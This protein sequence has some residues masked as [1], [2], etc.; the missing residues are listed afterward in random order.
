ML[1]IPSATYR[2]QFNQYFT[3]KQALELIPYFKE[4]G[5]SDYYSSPIMKAEPGSL[6][7]YDVLD[8][9]QVNPEIGT[10]E[11]FGHLA[12]ALQEQEMGFVLDIVPNH[13]C[14]SQP[15][16]RW[17]TD[18]LENGPSSLYARYFNIVWKPP[19]AELRNKILLAV[20][21]QQYGKVI[22]NQE[23][24]LAYEGG[25]FFV[26]YGGSHF[27]INPRTWNVILKPVVQLAE[28][29]LGENHPDILEIQSIL[30]AIDHLPSLS[31][32]DPEK[33]KERNREKEIVKKRLSS[34]LDN[35]PAILKAVQDS[36]R[37]LNGV[38]GDPHSF[39]RLEE[40]L[41]SQAYRLSYWRVT[42]DE[43]NYRR[44]F[45]VSK[46]A[47]IRVE[48]EEVFSA[49]HELVFKWIKQKWVTGL[50]V[51][52]VDGLF[53]PEYYLQRLQQGCWEAS[54]GEKIA[55]ANRCFYVLVEKILVGKEQ[56]RSQWPVYGTTGYDF[57]NLVNGLFIVQDHG[58]SIQLIYDH[59][60]G[61]H[62]DLMEI[63]YICKKLILIA[64]MSSELHILA[65][66]LE[67][68]SEQH[69]WSRDFTLESLRFA[70]REMIACFPVYRSYIR[71][72][73]GQVSSED[74]QYIISAIQQAKRLNPAIDLSIFD[75]IQSVLLLEDPVGLTNDQIAHRRE[76]VMRFQQLTGPVTAKGFED[77]AFYRTY[78][79]VSINDVGMN[80]LTFGVSIDQ[81]HEKN[82]ER[83]EKWPHTLLATFTHDTKRSED[84]RTRIDVLAEDPEGWKQALH[85]WREFNRDKKIV[86]DNREVPD[87][88]EEYLLYQTLIGSWPLYPMDANARANYIDRIDQ[89]MNKA[90][91]EAKFHTSWITPNEEYEK[92]IQSF[93]R[94]I[95][96]LDHAATFLKDFTDY[97]K[98]IVRA[99]LFNSLCQTLVK[100]T[101]PGVPDFYQGSELWEF[102]LVD[103]DNRRPVDYSSRQQ[104][105]YSLKE[106]AQQDS[107]S[108]V[109][110]LIENLEDGRIKLYLTFQVL[111]FRLQHLSL[112]NEGNYLPIQVAGA[113]EK[114]VIAWMRQKDHQQI[115]VVI[116][117][118]FT[119]LGD[120][121]S[122]LP[123][124][125]SIWQDTA[126]LCSE[127]QPGP[128]R[129]V[130][131]GQ[132]W[133]F[134]QPSWQVA[135]LF[136]KLP[137]VLL[138]KINQ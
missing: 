107:L 91:K 24:N 137:L 32:R 110:H 21:G 66:H 105:L 93:I 17:W 19:K 14:I 1:R 97:M 127:F 74:R 79:L 106:Q 69:R 68:V 16:N 126:L 10:E 125:P 37:S 2:L 42:N 122:T 134:N 25:A 104:L 57:L 40:L 90:L 78:P 87:S 39:D 71:A 75:F 33:I 103:P 76:F 83:Y 133:N 81:F 47:S 26:E 120:M 20:L 46:L 12:L 100:M 116:G 73:E 86:I 27:P 45:D 130:L 34:L 60:I 53:D 118:W 123:L 30:T 101:C 129:D 41:K 135:E 119:Q 51:D 63:I 54:T 38:K 84:V 115:V 4:L 55:D 88:K 44:F 117:R 11:E 35:Q 85:R 128:Y 62:E 136:S 49:V 65:R 113:R 114:H 59:F 121:A 6:H 111:N 22:E 99:G 36:L 64:S 80:P 102:T 58:A 23:L 108:L 89:Y 67:E 43:I 132:V 8:Y 70:L 77:T 109:S 13:M 72:H 124:G 3:F 18:V 92:G 7:G 29:E 50:R 82:K 28:K 61:R 9:T 95:F 96:A 56:L 15:G 98:P 48:D 94:K 5:I 52:H 31:D 131:T 112:F 138:E